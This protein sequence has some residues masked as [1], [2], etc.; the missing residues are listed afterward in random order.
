MKLKTVFK[1]CLLMWSYL[2]KSGA[3]KKEEFFE[4]SEGKK[5]MK[6]HG[7]HLWYECAACMY[8]SDR[9]NGIYAD[10]KCPLMPLWKPKNPDGVC[11]YDCEMGKSPYR[12]WRKEK[13][14][15]RRKIYAQ[16]IVDFCRK[17]L[18]KLT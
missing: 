8:V 2:A 10:G 11:N 1:E 4:T 9:N 13:K 18:K 12:L 16:R 7:H 6:R 5:Y 3:A 14:K 17:E 15:G